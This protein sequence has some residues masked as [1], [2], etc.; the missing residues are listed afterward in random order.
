MIGIIITPSAKPPASRAELPERQHRDA[1]GEHADDDRRNAVQRVRSKS[2]RA[3][4]PAAAYS[5]M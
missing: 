4:E 3:G 1:V 5:D 2:H